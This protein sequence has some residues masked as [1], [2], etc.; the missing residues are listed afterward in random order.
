MTDEIK[1]LLDELCSHA[2]LNKAELLSGNQRIITQQELTALAAAYAAR[3]G[4][5]NYVFDTKILKPNVPA[6]L[7]KIWTATLGNHWRL[8]LTKRTRKKQPTFFINYGVK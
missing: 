2:G 7:K 4:H 8:P 5:Y 6:N 3:I 1:I